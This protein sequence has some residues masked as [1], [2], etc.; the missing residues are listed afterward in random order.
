M[1]AEYKAARRPAG[2]FQIRN[3]ESGMVFVGSAQD[4]PGIL[5][6]NR[7]QLAGGTH[8]NRRLQEDWKRLGPAS[9]TFETLDELEV[10]DDDAAALRRELAQLEELWLEKLQPYGSRGYND[11]PA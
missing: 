1:K 10:V 5:N 6:S 7:F 3:L 8:P 4:I 11:G 9:F 2:V